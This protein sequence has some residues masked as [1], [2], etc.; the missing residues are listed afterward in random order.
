MLL[1]TLPVL[2]SYAAEDG[3]FTIDFEDETVGEAAKNP[4]ISLA[5]TDA[6]NTV[7]VETDPK[8]PDNKVLKLNR[9]SK[10][11]HAYVNIPQQT[12]VFVAE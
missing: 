7:T 9:A 2:M 12:G 8:N 10:K 4:A 11:M 6:N 1:G 3:I 5:E